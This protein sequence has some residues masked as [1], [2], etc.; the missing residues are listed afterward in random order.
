MVGLPI[1]QSVPCNRS[2]DF[3]ASAESYASENSRGPRR[4]C[5]TSH[6]VRFGSTGDWSMGEFPWAFLSLN[7]IDE[8]LA[9]HSNQY[10]SIFF[11]QPVMLC[12]LEV[13]QIAGSSIG[14]RTVQRYWNVNCGIQSAT[15][16]TVYT[17]HQYAVKATLSE[18][19]HSSK[20]DMDTARNSSSAPDFL[21]ANWFS[22]GRVPE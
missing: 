2:C 8:D 19:K 5:G 3:C 13:S 10:C 9:S 21:G 16:Y 1:G 7:R 6:P 20:T 18:Q 22:H 14:K 12:Q 15:W 17:V 4:S 11:R